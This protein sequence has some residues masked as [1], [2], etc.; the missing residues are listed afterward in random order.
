[1]NQMMITTINTQYDESANILAKLI[2]TK[3][4]NIR[5]DLSTGSDDVRTKIKS[6]QRLKYCKILTVRDR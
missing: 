3:L 5:I 2:Q 6:A 1:M 4:M